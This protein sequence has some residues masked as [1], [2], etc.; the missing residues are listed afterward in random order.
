MNAS[1][2]RKA[3]RREKPGPL[4]SRNNPPLAD[5]RRQPVDSVPSSTKP[6]VEARIRPMGR[7]KYLPDPRCPVRPLAPVHGQ[8]GRACRGVAARAV[9]ERG[10]AMARRRVNNQPAAT[11]DRNT[12]LSG[13]AVF[14]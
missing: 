11:I 1:V 8:D 14:E 7:F 13:P 5:H 4:P 12:A 3:D 9:C 2:P 10:L 6:A